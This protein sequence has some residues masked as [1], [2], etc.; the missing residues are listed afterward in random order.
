MQVQKQIYFVRHCHAHGQHRDSPLTT[1]GLKQAEQL[2][3]YF[4]KLDKRIDCI[5]S[6]PYL[7]AIDSIKPFA[8]K[9]DLSIHIDER[10]QE[11]MLSVQPID[12]WLEVLEH[13]FQEPDFA[14]P[15]GESSNDAFKRAYPILDEIVQQNDYQNI[16]IVSHGNLIALLLNHFDHTFGFE[17]WKT[18]R[19]PDIYALQF[20]EE[21]ESPQHIIWQDLYK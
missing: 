9:Q 6:S 12:D 10:L 2:A 16:I 11:R 13:S 19:N 3:Y 5:I 20:C 8:M 14:L 17:Q 7:R 1:N 15:G 18:M 21:L 4:S